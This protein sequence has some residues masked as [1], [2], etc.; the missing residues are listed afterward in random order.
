MNYFLSN[1]F[2]GKVLWAILGLSAVAGLNLMDILS[3][4]FGNSFFNLWVVKI[5]VTAAVV[6]VIIYGVFLSKRAKKDRQLALLLPGFI[7]EKRSFLG[8]KV[9]EDREFQTFCHKC[10]HFDLDRLR[11]LLVLRERK[12][13]IK[14]KDD[15]PLRYCLYWNLEDLHPVMQLT[16][17]LKVMTEDAWSTE[18]NYRAGKTGKRKAANTQR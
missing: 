5:T 3:T 7:E 6:G 4:M 9:A 1:L 2:R 10:R 13:W 14:L 8:K 18:D 16:E 11:C 15:C 12:A 17:K